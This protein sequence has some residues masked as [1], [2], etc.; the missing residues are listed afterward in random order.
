ME[1][2]HVNITHHFIWYEVNVFVTPNKYAASQYGHTLNEVAF[3]FLSLFY[4]ICLINNSWNCCGIRK[5]VYEAYTTYTISVHETSMYLLFSCY[6]L[7]FTFTL[8]ILKLNYIL[9][10]EP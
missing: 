5:D 3:D 4:K 9:L 10:A 2:D 6:N 1:I 8:R 7:I